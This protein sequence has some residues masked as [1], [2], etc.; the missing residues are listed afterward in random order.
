MD[1]VITGAGGFIGRALV[2]RLQA[3]A[4]LHDSQGREFQPR[5]LVLCDTAPPRSGLDRSGGSGGPL[6]DWRI[7]SVADPDFVASL[8][9]PETACVFHLAGIV[10]GAAEADFDAGIRVNLDG[11]RNLLEALKQLGDAPGRDSGPVRLVHASSIAVYGAPVPARIDDD[12]QPWPTLSYGAHKLASELLIND[13]ARRGIVDGRSVRLSGVVVRPPQPNGALSAFNSDLIREPLAGRPVV[14]PVSAGATIWLQSVGAT[15]HNLLHAMALDP[16]ALKLQR[17]VLLPALACR[18]DE[19]VDTVARV[20]GEE[21]R[22]LV[23]Y[24]V[25]DRIEP[26]FGR[27]PRPFTATRALELGFRVDAGLETLI[28][29]YSA[30]QSSGGR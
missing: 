20:A 13:M 5:R 24:R 23:T 9:G 30:V 26:M 11:T 2:S 15:I 8:T 28:S 10:S 17:A 29:D 3:G 6:L 16:A 22:R 27:W 4:T 12:T 7:G 18:I 21:A 14:S 1:V 19:I 25:D